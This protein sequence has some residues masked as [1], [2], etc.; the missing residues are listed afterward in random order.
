M[1]VSPVATEALP[2]IYAQLAAA[3]Y[4][5]AVA[6]ID[7]AP[8]MQFCDAKT[9][10]AWFVAWSGNK[11]LKGTE[12]RILGR[13]RCGGTAVIWIRDGNAPLET[14]PIVHFGS[15]GEITLLAKHAADYAWLLA[16]GVGPAEVAFAEDDELATYAMVRFA[17]FA[18][19]A[20]AASP[21]REPRQPVD[22]VADAKRAHPDAAAILR[23]QVWFHMAKGSG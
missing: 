15:D 4:R 5:T 2:P 3:P 16:H 1:R 6:Q 9:T 11:R 20:T 14:Q 18:A 13:D 10:Q 19:I 21:R 17:P 12:F 7:F 8:A 23:A 22:I